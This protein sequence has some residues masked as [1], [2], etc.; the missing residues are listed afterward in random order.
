MRAIGRQSLL[1]LALLLGACANLPGEAARGTPAAPVAMAS[2][3][4]LS[5]LGVPL[6][7]AV[8][9][10]PDRLLTNAHVLPPG[11]TNVLARRG[12]GRMATEAVVL[13][14][15]ARLDLAVLGV[16]PGI[17]LA[18][19]VE[20]APPVPGASIWAIGAPAAGPA[21]ARGRIEQSGLHLTGRGP[22]FTARIGAL[23]GYSG[24]PGIDAEGRIRGLVTALVRPGA[25]PV[26]AAL[27]GLDLDG[28][29]RN[30]E[31]REVFFLSID[32]AMAESE[33]IAR[34]RGQ[35]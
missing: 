12:D 10:A 4:A 34:N 3:A 15:S 11:V 8:A 26:L 24:G 32:V 1:L 9:V 7:S 27:T 29:S 33:R 13:G 20:A 23:M 22:G 6:G 31:F 25:A 28:L 16:A 18:A 21:I 35:D 30:G 19:T 17:F 5:T 14:R 2:F